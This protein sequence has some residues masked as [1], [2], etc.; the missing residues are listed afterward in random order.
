MCARLSNPA[1]NDIK[2]EKIDAEKDIVIRECLLN[3]ATSSLGGKLAYVELNSGS[4]SEANK[5]QAGAESDKE[6]QR[7]RKRESHEKLTGM[8]RTRPEGW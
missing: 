1:A 2:N 6:K 4:F 3:V 7:A 5:T 8:R